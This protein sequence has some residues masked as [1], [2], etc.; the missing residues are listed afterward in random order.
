MIHRILA[1]SGGADSVCLLL[2]TLESQEP[3]TLLAA[4][5]NFH[6]RG[7]ESDRDETFCRQ[8]CKEKGVRIEVKHFDT[9]QYASDNK[10]SIE[11]AARDLRY[12]WFEELRERENADA[13]LV[14]HHQ[15]DNIETM[16]MNLMRGTGIKGMTGMKERNG[17]I[18]RPLLSM[19]RN[20]IEEYLHQR[21]QSYVTDS[22]NMHADVIRNKIRLQLLPLME[23]IFPQVRKNMLKT[24]R[25]LSQAEDSL[26]AND[27]N[28][29]QYALNTF[30]L[31]NG[32]SSA[33]VE[34]IMRG[35]LRLGVYEKPHAVT[36]PTITIKEYACT[37]DFC[38][39]RDACRVTLD[40][41]CVRQPLLLRKASQGD[42]FKPYGMKGCSKLLSDFFTDLKI[43]ASERDNQYVVTDATG[44]IIWVVGLRVA[45]QVAC[46]S[47]TQRVIELGI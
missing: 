38:P 29:S 36:I 8:L 20:E 25:Y 14:A 11:M 34:A 27:D 31:E 23:S 24:M 12:A 37:E 3:Q 7:E 26:T 40:A 2:K 42:R 39:S 16:L 30:L 47:K 5:C 10:I 43:P 46:T 19:S 35:D 6:L 18:E 4:H 45:Q 15:D 17:Y 9:Q 32:F 33:Q 21:G 13:I 22:T 41:D 44:E 28:G 1:L